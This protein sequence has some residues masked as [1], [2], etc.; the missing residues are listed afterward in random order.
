MVKQ[1]YNLFEIGDEKKRKKKTNKEQTKKQQQ[2]NNKNKK[3]TKKHGTLDF[4]EIQCIND[5]TLTVA[6]I[7]SSTPVTTKLRPTGHILP[8]T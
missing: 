4:S 5:R 3:Q 7:H 1:I 2:K 8:V 6:L